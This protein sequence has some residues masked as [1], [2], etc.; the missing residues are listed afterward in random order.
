MYK[1]GQVT[2]FI[3]IALLVVA[4]VALVFTLSPKL[5]IGGAEKVENPS[6][7]IQTCLEDTLKEKINTISNQGGS[8]APE[9][10]YPY[11]DEKLQYLCYTNTFYETCYVQVPFIT[12]HIEDEL[13]TSIEKEVNACFK[14]LE[15][16]YKKKNYEV[17][18]DAGE[19]KVELLPHRVVA[20]IERK[21]ILTKGDEKETY[22]NFR[23]I[24]NNN[25]YELSRIASSIVDW[26]A[27]YGDA[28]PS[29]YMALYPELKVEKH[30]QN[31]GTAIYIITE[32]ESGNKFQFAS[33]SLLTSLAQS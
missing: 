30:L 13:T 18:V 11:N 15:E 5:K 26:E 31:D 20:T 8:L 28:D 4:A 6:S 23:V 1:R 21:L 16:S 24:V 27:T 10:Y 17:N 7:F 32:R 14:S 12:K 29:A 3:I 9:F 22:E 33:R 2:I 25:I 19:F